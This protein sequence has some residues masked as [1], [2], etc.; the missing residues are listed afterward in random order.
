MQ[1]NITSD[2]EVFIQQKITEG[3]Y[4]S[5]HELVEDAIRLLK[6]KD[7]IRKYRIA[8]VDS[9]LKAGIKSL[10][11]GIFHTQEDVDK[12]FSEKFGF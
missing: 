1:I 9:K 2:S 3:N 4:S 8:E 12:Y 11:E 7:I 10:A 6:E 5:P